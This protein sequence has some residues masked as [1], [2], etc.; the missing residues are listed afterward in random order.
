M[1]REPLLRQK[2]AGVQRRLI[3]LELLEPGIARSGYS[4]YQNGRA[5]GRVTSGTKSPTLGKSIALGYVQHG[6]E[7][8]DENIEVE[9]RGRKSRA[10]IVSLP[11][12]RR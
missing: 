12:V 8:R 6:V 10:K 9:I 7:A 5:V 4:L 11:F 1:G 3:G 2:S